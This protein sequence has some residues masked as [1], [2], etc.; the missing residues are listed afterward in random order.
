MTS[1]STG[2]LNVNTADSRS[3]KN[4]RCEL[5]QQ[6]LRLGGEAFYRVT[7]L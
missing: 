7:V 2:R 3:R 4:W 1:R 5:A 6:H